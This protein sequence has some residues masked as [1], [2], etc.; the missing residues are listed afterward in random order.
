MS[1]NYEGGSPRKDPSGS[2]FCLKCW[3]RHIYGKSDGNWIWEEHRDHAFSIPEEWIE[4]IGE[5]CLSKQKTRDELLTEYL[6]R[7]LERDGIEVGD[8]R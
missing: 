3:R 1:D 7:G 6:R 2:Y 8:G 5:A 4:P